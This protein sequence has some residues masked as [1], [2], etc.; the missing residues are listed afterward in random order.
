MAGDAAPRRVVLDNCV[1]RTLTR[2]L[3]GLD[4]RRVQDFGWEDEDDGPLLRHLEAVC[5]VFVTVDRNLPFQQRL[6][7]RPFATVVLMGK[8]NRITDLL[9]LLPRLMDLIPRVEV[10]SVTRIA[11]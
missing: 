1:P 4:V 6:E 10:G 11:G 9:P 2:Y 3:S 8:S 7:Q 5:D